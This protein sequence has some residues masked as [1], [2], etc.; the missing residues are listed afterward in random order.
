MWRWTAESER[1]RE[2]YDRGAQDAK[3]DGKERYAWQVTT[4]AKG[5]ANDQATARDEAQ[6]YALALAAEIGFWKFI[7]VDS[8]R[9]IDEIPT[10]LDLVTYLI[11]KD[12]R[13]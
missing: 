10:G 9:S 2:N 1:L 12:T 5:I 3:D 6:K 13:S 7:A 4:Q 8:M 11:P